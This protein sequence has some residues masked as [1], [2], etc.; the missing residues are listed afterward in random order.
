VCAGGKVKIP[1][2]P[3]AQ[4]RAASVGTIKSPAPAP[5]SRS[6]SKQQAVGLKDAKGVAM[7]EF[8]KWLY[9]ELGRGLIGIADSK[10]SLCR[11]EDGG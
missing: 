9:R 11:N 7:D 1:T 6:V 3:A 8:K 5:A 2:G 4:T 10:W